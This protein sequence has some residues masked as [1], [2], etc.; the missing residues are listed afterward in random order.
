MKY[1]TN[2]SHMPEGA[3]HWAPET[4][5]WLEAWYRFEDG[6]WYQVNQY[7]AYDVAERPY[8]MPAAG[9]KGAGVPVLKRPISDL[10]SVEDFVK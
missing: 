6:L 4:D 9:W 2:I 8:G 7:W 5:N 3:T 1:P 10:T